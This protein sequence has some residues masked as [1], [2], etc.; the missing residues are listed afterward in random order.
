MWTARVLLTAAAA[1]VVLGA[2]PAAGQAGDPPSIGEV[3][4]WSQRPGAAAAPAGG[5]EVAN[6]LGRDQSIAALRM[7]GG[8]EPASAVL[9]LDESGGRAQDAATLRVCTV[10]DEWAAANPGP[11]GDAPGFDCATAVPLERDAGTMTWRGEVADLLTGGATSLMVVPDAGG[12]ALPVNAGYE[13]SFSAARLEVTSVPDPAP[14]PAAPAPSSSG[15]TP[16]AAVGAAPPGPGPNASG[17]TFAVPNTFVDP[18]PSVPQPAAPTAAT[19]TEVAAPAPV[20]ALAGGTG[21]SPLPQLPVD[22]ADGQAGSGPPWG[23]LLV[24]VPLCAG[25]GVAAAYGRRALSA[26]AVAGA[27]GR[28]AAA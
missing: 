19:A 15:P 13:I 21:T 26:R 23:R 12:D 10:V 3:G 28:G 18:P 16:T 11:F 8:D 5:F 25:A 27:P 14:A 6:G 9:V 22:T 4:W 24:L 2:P 17:T 20:D 1:A 7:A